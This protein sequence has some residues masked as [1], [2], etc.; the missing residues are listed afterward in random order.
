[1]TDTT[2]TKRYVANPDGLPAHYPTHAHDPKF[3]EA[4]GRTVATFGFLEEVLAKAIF[5]FT[6]KKE[7]PEEEVAVA[8]EKWLSTLEKSLADPLGRLITGYDTAVREHGCATITNLD[9]LIRD[10]RDASDLRNALCHGSWRKPDSQGRSIPFFFNR[11]LRKFETPVDVKFLDQT[12][13]C[14][15]RLAC[16][17][18][19]TV[20]YMGWQFPGSD[21]P[22]SPL[23]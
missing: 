7:I 23:V 18:V 1:M 21:G 9:D 8:L 2:D 5:S 13:K 6:G 19:S 20:T 10:L 17:V 4:L 15:V 16:M 14:A 22:G 11:N 12:Q 3:W